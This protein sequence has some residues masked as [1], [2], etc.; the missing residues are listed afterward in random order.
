MARLPQPGGDSGNWGDILNDYLAQAHTATGVL[1]DNSVGAAQLQDNAVTSLA[2]AP[3]SVTAAQ[4]ADGTIQE[5]QLSTT[6]TAKLNAPAVVADGSVTKTKLEPSVQA[7][8]DK[9]D[10]AVQANSL[11]TVATSG[12]YSDLQNKPTIPNVSDATASNKGIVQLTGDLGGTAANPT[13]PG[14]A[15]KYTKPSGGVPLSDILKSDLDANYTRFGQSGRPALRMARPSLIRNT[16]GGNFLGAYGASSNLTSTTDVIGQPSVASYVTNGGGG[17]GGFGFASVTWDMSGMV[18][19][20]KWKIS[21]WANVNYITLDIAAGGS[22]G[23]YASMYQV[24]LSSEVGV[25]R[26]TLRIAR[27]GEWLV[28]DFPRSAFTVTGTPSW[29]TVTNFRIIGVDKNNIPFTMLIDSISGVPDSSAFP[30]GAVIFTLDDSDVS[31]WTLARTRLAR[32]GYPATLFPILEGVSGSGIGSGTGISLDQLKLLRDTE[33]WE[34]GMHATTYTTHTTGWTGMSDAQL[35]TELDTIRAWQARNGFLSDMM[36]YPNG[37]TSAQT[38]SIAKEYGIVARM[39][40]GGVQSIGL[41]MP[42]RLPAVN[43]GTRTIAQL[44]A[45]IDQAKAA[46]TPVIFMGHRIVTSG[47]VGNDCLQ[48]SW[49]GAIDYCAANSVPVMTLSE[50]IRKMMT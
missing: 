19:R 26:N 17:Y 18:V 30:N 31:Q 28:M 21:D 16:V 45:S 4:I 42:M 23:S 32:Y 15:G 46:K 48:S 9:A 27:S 43:I 14:L 22:A 2:L 41:N 47:A 3:D 39:T 49:E 50:A 8:L 29:S 10:T 36:A 44:T 35:R 34:I 11:S 37:D 38:E 33:G 1:K 40:S 12:S 25:A 7:S 6:V 24:S 5:A 20:L 13:V